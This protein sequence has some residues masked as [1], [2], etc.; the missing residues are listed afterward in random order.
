[1]VLLKRC[2]RCNELQSID[3]FG[4]DASKK[5]GTRAYCNTCKNARNKEQYQNN[6]DQR[7]I[8]HRDTNRQ[9]RKQVIEGYGG[10]C[11]CCGET[12]YEFLAIDHVY[13]GGSKERDKIGTAGICRKILQEGFPPEYRL[14][15]HNCNMSIGAWGYCPHKLDKEPYEIQDEEI[16]SF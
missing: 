8:Y 9:L 2:S 11:E 16:S 10:M 12:A 1:M 6:I 14:L 15:C 5:E 3:E 7:R 13:G 4:I